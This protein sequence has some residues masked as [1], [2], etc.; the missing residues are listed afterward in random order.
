[1]LRLS[2]VSE[3]DGSE[4]ATGDVD[5]A[6]I[7]MV[8]TIEPQ[9]SRDTGQRCS[10]RWNGRTGCVGSGLKEEMNGCSIVPARHP[11]P[12]HDSGRRDLLSAPQGMEWE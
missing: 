1:M 11:V 10:K 3:T 2:A 5:V 7:G 4:A 9:L 8:W 12:S 6:G